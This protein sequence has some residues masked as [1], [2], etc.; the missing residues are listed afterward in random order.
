[1][2]KEAVAQMAPVNIQVLIKDLKGAIAVCQ[3]FNAEDKEIKMGRLI[4][5]QEILIFLLENKQ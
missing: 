2:S 4:T 5:L 1:M 3:K